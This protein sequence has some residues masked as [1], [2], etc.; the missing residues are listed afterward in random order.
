[1]STFVKFNSAVDGKRL[2]I[3][4]DAI[5]AAASVTQD[6]SDIIL[7]NGI[8]F[9]VRGKLDSIVDQAPRLKPVK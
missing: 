9:R 5:V 8:S 2:L 4:V 7:S 3:D 1:M 6:T